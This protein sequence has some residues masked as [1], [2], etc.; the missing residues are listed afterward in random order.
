MNNF[1]S[2]GTNQSTAG[3]YQKLM[4]PD[5]QKA[6]IENFDKNK[7]PRFIDTSDYR[8]RF[9]TRG[10]SSYSIKTSDDNSENNDNKILQLHVDERE[11]IGINENV[12]ATEINGCLFAI[13]VPDNAE[14]YNAWHFNSV[15]KAILA[16][17][18]IEA[19]FTM[20][21]PLE[22]RSAYREAESWLEMLSLYPGTSYLC[23]NDDVTDKL[24]S[25]FRVSP[26]N[27]TKTGESVAVDVT[28]NIA[29]RT[30]EVRHSLEVDAADSELESG[31]EMLQEH[32]GPSYLYGP[33]DAGDDLEGNPSDID[34][35]VPKP[36]DKANSATE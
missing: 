18:L 23:A 33:N 10:L 27:F 13:H 12:Q 14:F 32:P 20:E 7:A 24:R 15:N 26:A 2:Y 1:N 35:A 31:K 9:E 25:V 21:N 36:E 3:P 4:E 11:W 28:F 5:R 22:V 16:D 30:F 34:A 6:I 29:T 8:Y 19:M 17:D